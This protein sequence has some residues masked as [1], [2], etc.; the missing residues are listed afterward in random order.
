ME[1]SVAF[2]SEK[3]ISVVSTVDVRIRAAL[4]L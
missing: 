2:H 4:I 1:V 3:K